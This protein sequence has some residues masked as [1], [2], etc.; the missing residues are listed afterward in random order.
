MKWVRHFGYWFDFNLFCSSDCLFN[1]P[2]DFVVAV[3]PSSQHSG[4]YNVIVDSQSFK[5]ET[6]A[7]I[8]QIYPLNMSASDAMASAL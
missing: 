2:L 6:E 4:E 7:I 5:N 3:S 8:S 1:A